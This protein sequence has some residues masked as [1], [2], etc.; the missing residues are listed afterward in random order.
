MFYLLGQKVALEKLG[1]A[2]PAGFMR[3]LRNAWGA[4]SP[5][6]QETAK[7]VGIGTGGGALI[8]GAGGALTSGGADAEGKPKQNLLGRILGGALL[9]G[10]LGGTGAYGLGKLKNLKA[11]PGATTEA[12]ETAAK[13][14][15]V[16]TPA[17]PAAANEILPSASEFMRAAPNEVL[18]EHMPVLLQNLSKF[19]D[20]PRAFKQFLERVGL[21]PADYVSKNV[22]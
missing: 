9:G 18:S 2:P 20:D 6:A 12:A 5:A 8:G 21:N 15:P 17:A 16:P 3:Q 14:A 22:L 7:R 11:A 1:Q 4:L 19:Q 10:A 13:A